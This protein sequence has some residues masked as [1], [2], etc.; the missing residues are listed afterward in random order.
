M[1]RRRGVLWTG[2]RCPRPQSPHV[3]Y[4]WVIQSSLA[5]STSFPV[6]PQPKPP[7]ASRQ[8]SRQVS[9][10]RRPSGSGCVYAPQFREEYGLQPV[11]IFLPQTACHPE[12]SGIRAPCD[13]RVARSSGVKDLLLVSRF[14]ECVPPEPAQQIDARI[15]RHGSGYRRCRFA[16]AL[17]RGQVSIFLP[18]NQIACAREA[19]N[20]GCSGL[21]S[22]L[23]GLLDVIDY[24]HVHWL[25]PRFELQSQLL[26]QCC[27]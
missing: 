23:R 16:Q 4:N 19:Q 18:L 14:Q 21:A 26:L 8:P 7:A 3:G 20:A 15:P 17:L 10:A 11:R 5:G 9:M 25:F 24:D 6:Y 27:E 22:V 13:T 1:L 2:A 12:R